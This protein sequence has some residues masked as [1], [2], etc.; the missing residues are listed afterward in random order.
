MAT[1]TMPR[2]F[3]V[4]LAAAIVAGF[5]GL[6][7]AHDLRAVMRVLPDGVVL[8]AGFDD[9]TPA[10]G[11]RVVILNSAGVEI[12]SG[13]TDERGLCPLPKIA[14]GRYTATVESAGHRDE[15]SFEVAAPE[16]LDAPLEYVRERPDKTL[17]VVI[18]VG[19]LLAVSFAFWWLRLR[20][21]ATCHV[22]SER[23]PGNG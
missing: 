11:A 13:T 2:R 20:K 8:E 9:D 23:R 17:G 22:T 7:S 4:L 15:V 6:A 3:L 19:A 1:H 5:P 14:A 12:A 18:G 16:F 10:Q 21:P